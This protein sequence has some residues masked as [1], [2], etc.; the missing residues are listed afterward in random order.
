MAAARAGFVFD[1]LSEHAVDE[2][3]A[4]R[5]ERARRYLGWPMLFLMRLLP[6]SERS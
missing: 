3:L 1:H 4:N 2:S 5:M 6:G